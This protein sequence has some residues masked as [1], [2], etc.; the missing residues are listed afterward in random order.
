MQ[1]GLLLMVK[2]AV[3]TD[4]GAQGTDPP[5]AG[6]RQNFLQEE[7]LE[8]PG[9]YKRRSLDFPHNQSEDKILVLHTGGIPHAEARM[10]IGTGAI[11][12]L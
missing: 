1:A 7:A 9:L 2:R 3:P 4:Q 10:D 8:K 5:D 11:Q 12:D 6:S